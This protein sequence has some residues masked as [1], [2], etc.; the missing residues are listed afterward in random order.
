[1]VREFIVETIFHFFLTHVLRQS[2]CLQALWVQP[3]W[4]GVRYFGGQFA[5][6][7]SG[8]HFGTGK[9]WTQLSRFLFDKKTT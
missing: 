9:Y 8:P 5:I 6:L 1:M 2:K 3:R 7:G 4:P